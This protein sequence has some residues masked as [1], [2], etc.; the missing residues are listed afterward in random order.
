[1]QH[2]LLLHGALGHPG[3]FEFIKAQLAAEY[4]IH[5][6]VFEGHT[7]AT[8][9]HT[10]ISM[11]AYVSQV[12][13]YCEENELAQ[14]AIFGYSMGGYVGLCYAAQF[15]E[16][17]TAVMTLATKLHWSPEIAAQEAKMLDPE[18]IQEKVPK[19]AAQLS[20][21]HGAG[22]WEQLC[23]DIAGLLSGLGEQ[24]LLAKPDF[25]AIKAKTQ[26]MVGDKDNMVSIEETLAAVKQINQ[27]NLAVLPDTIHPFEKINR[28]LLLRLMRDFFKL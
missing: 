18:M 28:E 15:P 11:P 13:K 19:F 10:E 1:M 2:L 24:P 7:A 22:N 5:T 27:A 25:A 21:V 9:K 23:R 12:R 17:V 26:L 6:P 4:V 16:R 8:R 20:A 14:A 3:Y